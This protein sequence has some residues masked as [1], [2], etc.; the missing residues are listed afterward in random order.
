M[1]KHR[2][3]N[4]HIAGPLMTCCQIIP[5]SHCSCFVDLCALFLNGVPVLGDV[6]QPEGEP[7]E[8]GPCECCNDVSHC[9]EAMGNF[10][11]LK[12]YFTAIC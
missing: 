6:P 8:V 9:L 7:G 5:G 2:D 10:E 11:V 4:H 1:L 12:Q 3:S